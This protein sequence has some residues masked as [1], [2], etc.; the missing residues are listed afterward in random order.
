MAFAA[1]T[2]R[3]TPPAR[4]WRGAPGEGRASLLVA[5]T[6]GAVSRGV[7]A[8]AVVKVAAAAVGERVLRFWSLTGS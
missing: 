2:P 6:P 5:V 7:K 3:V 4:E 8:G 1:R